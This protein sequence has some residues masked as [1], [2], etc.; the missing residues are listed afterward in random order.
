MAYDTQWERVQKFKMST[1]V[2]KKAQ[3]YS[4]LGELGLII[5]G[6]SGKE[7]KLSGGGCRVLISSVLEAPAGLDS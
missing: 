4:F 1:I 6:G 3:L 7:Q 2:F 5:R